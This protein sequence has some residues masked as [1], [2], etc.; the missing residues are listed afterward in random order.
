MIALL[1]L[2][3]F[4]A[5]WLGGEAP[6]YLKAAV[7]GGMVG[8]FAAMIA[9]LMVV[10]FFLAVI[11]FGAPWTVSIGAACGWIGHA[12]RRHLGSRARTALRGSYLLAAIGAGLYGFLAPNAQ[13]AVPWPDPEVSIRLSTWG[14]HTSQWRMRVSTPNGSALQEMWENWG[15]AT[16]ANIYRTPLGSVAIAGA[17]SYG[18]VIEFAAD[19]KPRPGGHRE[20][21]DA[22]QWTY[23]GA[24]VQRD[25]A[26]VFV[27]PTQLPECVE[28]FG[29]GTIPPGREAFRS[30]TGC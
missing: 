4:C 6:S 8:A 16:R 11:L 10:P 1:S 27:S 22:S 25:S 2:P 3:A 29:E 5:V 21:A 12:L 28:T 13:A 18:W 15:P 24:V 26:L 30:A 7:L 17:G 14:F 19:G 23:I 20:L 9:G